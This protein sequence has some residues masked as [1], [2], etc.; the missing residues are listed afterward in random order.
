MKRLLSIASIVFSIWAEIVQPPISKTPIEAI[1]LSMDFVNRVCLPT[2]TPCGTGITL[3]SVSAFQ[4]SN[5]LD[6]TSTIIVPSSPA[7]AVIPGTQRVSFRVQAGTIN[8]TYVLSVK[9]QNATTAERLEG[10]IVM[11]IIQN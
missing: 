8:Q 9:V 3:T 7:P 5:G 6:V 11:R 1:D 4:Q 10:S 2:G